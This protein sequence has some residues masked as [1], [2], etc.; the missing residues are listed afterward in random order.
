[1]GYP[2]PGGKIHHSRLGK[3]ENAL[4]FP[5]RSRCARAVDAVGRYSGD[6]CINSCYDVQLFL[7]LAHLRAGASLA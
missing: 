2:V 3:A 7:K 5:H 1:M 6:R 4:K